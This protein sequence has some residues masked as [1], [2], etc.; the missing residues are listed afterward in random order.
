[1][2]CWLAQFSSVPCDGHLVKAHLVERQLIRK[3]F[4]YGAAITPDGNLVP[5]PRR[6][7]W[8]TEAGIYVGMVPK[9]DLMVDPRSYVWACGGAMGNSGHHGMLD[10]YQIHGVAWLRADGVADLYHGELDDEQP[11]AVVRAFLR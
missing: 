4:P 10:N 6:D 1:M 8:P 5:A 9:R 3:E 7:L 2:P 11:G